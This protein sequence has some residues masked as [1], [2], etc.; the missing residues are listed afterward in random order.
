MSGIKAHNAFKNFLTK[1]ETIEITK[2][3]HVYYLGQKVKDF[4]IQ[5]PCPGD[6]KERPHSASSAKKTP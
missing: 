3:E 4:K 1:Y 5:A 6:L 2:Y